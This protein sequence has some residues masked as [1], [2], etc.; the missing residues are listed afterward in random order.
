MDVDK[1]IQFILDGLA[2]LEANVGRHDEEIA[3]LRARLT[4]LTTL[5]STLA[6]SMNSLALAQQQMAISEA[7]SHRRRNESH[8][9]SERELRIALAALSRK[10]KE[11][12]QQ[13]RLAQARAEEKL[14]ASQARSEES[15]RARQAQSEE[16]LRARQVR[17]KE[18]G[19][20]GDDIM[21]AVRYAAYSHLSPAAPPRAVTVA[22]AMTSEDPTIAMLQRRLALKHSADASRP[23]P[24]AHSRYG[25][26]RA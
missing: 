26:S 11:A 6:E 5:V 4:A 23:Q 12:E 1:A 21:D 20:P 19:D 8:A 2:R 24:Y 22:R 10:R 14:R 18:P 3:E 15:L 9:E 7:E 13:L 17:S 25:Y 16:R